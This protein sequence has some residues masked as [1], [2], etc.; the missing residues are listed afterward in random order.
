MLRNDERKENK[1]S[2]R[3]LNVTIKPNRTHACNALTIFL[4]LQFPGIANANIKKEAIV[5]K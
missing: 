2:H 1:K 3:N 5:T 4:L